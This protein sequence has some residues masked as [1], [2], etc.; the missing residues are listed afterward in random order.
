MNPIAQPPS[1]FFKPTYTVPQFC[2]AH[3]VSRTH[4]Y[5]LWKEDKGPR[6][7]KVGRRTL[8]SAEAAADWRKRMEDETAPWSAQ[9][10]VDPALVV[11]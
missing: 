10:F 8:I 11:M 6:L 4:L 1:Y 9:G 2:D 5:A 7:M 3:N